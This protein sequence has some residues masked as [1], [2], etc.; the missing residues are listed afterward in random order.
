M[1]NMLASKD[2]TSEACRALKPLE[3]PEWKWDS[4]RMDF[5]VG[6]PPT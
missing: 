1:F 6:L 4:V 3:V 2:G 5:V